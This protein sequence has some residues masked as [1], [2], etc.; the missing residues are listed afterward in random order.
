MD[1]FINRIVL[2]QF[3]T[4][5]VKSFVGYRVKEIQNLYEKGH[6]NHV[7]THENPTDIAS[8]GALPSEL[9]NNLLW[10]FGPDWLTLSQ[11]SWTKLIPIVSSDANLEEKTPF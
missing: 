6:W 4:H 3:V 7:R 8:R 5:K 1:R 2:S 11:K 9:N 10:F